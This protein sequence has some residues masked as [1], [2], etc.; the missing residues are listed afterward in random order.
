[1]TANNAF[2]AQSGGV[3]AVINA[4]ACGLIQEARRLHL[5]HPQRIGK[6]YA[7]H[8]GILGAL[9]EDLIDT[10]RESDADI[11]RLRYSPGGAFG[12]SRFHLG[13]LSTHRAHFE[14]LVEVFR[15]HEIGYFFFN[16][17]DGSMGAAWHLSQTLAELGHPLTVIGI[18]KTVDNDLALTDTCPGFGSVAK[19]VA[20]S[21]R[22]AGFDVA[23]MARTS[24]RVFI[25]EAMGRHAG[26]IA[27][28][29]GLASESEGDPP[30][31][32]LFPEVRFDA[33]RFLARVDECVQRHGY[34]AIA[35]AEGL[36]DDGGCEI[37]GR[38][39]DDLPSHTR[40]GGVG[41]FIGE[42][43]HARFGHKYHLALADYL[44]RAARHL[45][46]GTDVEQAH[47][48]GV[49]AVDRAVRGSNNIMLTLQRLSDRPYRWEIGEVPLSAVANKEHR[50]PAEFISVDGFHITEA[51]RTYLQ[52][53]IEGEDPPPFRR[54][55]PDYVRLANHRVSR[56]LP[57]FVP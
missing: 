44:Q 49:A 57:D 1:M 43:I 4:T 17:G 8:D 11:A 39:F 42:L 30:H 36:C 23:S 48:L 12:S 29:A 53:L 2:Y 24:T 32:L 25:L 52:P 14:R 26:W 28:A 34:C 19:Y 7:G 20:T 40:A 13:P 10:S 31:I 15:A 50:M 35:V 27:A 37:G 56:V 3:T 16:G 55:L 33:E 51:C 22:E 21:M 9:T 45:A 47:A 54:G 18:P 41:R 38:S 5:L 6:V 46:S